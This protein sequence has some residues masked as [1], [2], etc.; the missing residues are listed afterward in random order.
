M[1]AEAGTEP[2]PERR[3]LKMVVAEVNGIHQS[4]FRKHRKEFS[5]RRDA[6]RRVAVRL[7]NAFHSPTPCQQA[8]PARQS[9]ISQPSLKSA[10]TLASRAGGSWTWAG[11]GRPSV[12]ACPSQASYARAMPRSATSSARSAQAERE[13]RLCDAEFLAALV[14]SLRRWTKELSHGHKN[15]TVLAGKIS[16]DWT[17]KMLAA[18]FGQY[19]HVKRIRAEYLPARRWVVAAVMYQNVEG[20][21]TCV[22]GERDGDMMVVP[23]VAAPLIQQLLQSRAAEAGA[24]VQSSIS[25]PVTPTST[26]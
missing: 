21:A 9:N 13:S 6:R 19:G 8:A 12:A 22:H 20:A 1:V 4:R 7:A 11:L 23:V 17:S 15:R 25:L 10:A 2:E 16:I 18:Q 24:G 3:S 5:E 14:A 26:V